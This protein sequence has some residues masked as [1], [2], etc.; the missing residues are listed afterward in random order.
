M[1]ITIG[2]RGSQLALAQAEGF[3]AKIAAL[4]PNDEVVLEIVKTLGDQLSAP[5]ADQGTLG[6]VPQGLFT[7]EL[8]EAL[9]SGRIRGAIHS[10]KD[11][12]TILPAGIQYGP[13]PKREDCRDAFISKTG[14][15]FHELPP[16]SKV[17]T[18]SPRR[19]AQ[20]RSFRPELKVLPLRGNVDT[21]IRKL[22]DG[23]VD[24]L[25]IAAAGIKRLGREKEVTEYLD[26]EVI[27]PAPAQGILGFTLR[28]E[29]REFIEILKSLNDP[30]T[31]VCAEAERSFLKTLQGGCRIPVGALAKVEGE[32]LSLSGVIAHPNGEKVMRQSQRGLTARPVELGEKLAKEFLDNG[33]QEILKAFG[34][35][36]W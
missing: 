36:T 31:Q 4:M 18:S 28:Q 13:F 33:A 21:R 32:S 11:V 17:G 7:R 9:L 27:L 23:V 1:K 8:D 10:L 3:R 26:P 15:K 2:T 16:G 25:V 30:P 34:R 20:I 22:R 14:K 6:E 29:D 35:S 19:E 5:G 24:A 12:P